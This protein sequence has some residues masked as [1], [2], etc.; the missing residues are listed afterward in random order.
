MSRKCL[1]ILLPLLV[2]S[3]CQS[4][5]RQQILATDK[6]QVALRSI[7]SRVFDTSD[8]SL[9]NRTVIATLQDLGFTI[10]RV[11]E[12]L[13]VVTATKA[14]NYLMK[15][16]VSSRPRGKDQM[17][18][19]ASAQFNIEAVSDPEIYQKFFDSLSQAMFL[20]AHQVR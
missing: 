3:G 19:R 6:S 13:G 14:G 20:E 16:T 1:W 15:M 18:V 9:T 4:D 5:S 8:Q 2:L 7:Q 10:D 17:F 11:D 12:D